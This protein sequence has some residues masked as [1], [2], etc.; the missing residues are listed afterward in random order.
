YRD[1]DIMQIDER[2]LWIDPLYQNLDARGN[3]TT[4]EPANVNTPSPTVIQPLR[5]E[6]DTGV[7]RLLAGSGAAPGKI[8]LGEARDSDSAA[9]RFSGWWNRRRAANPVPAFSGEKRD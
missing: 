6:A 8:S 3:P 2:G 7:V 9:G 1:M 4:D 5:A